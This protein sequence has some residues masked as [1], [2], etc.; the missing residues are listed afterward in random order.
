MNTYTVSKRSGLFVTVI[1]F[2]TILTGCSGIQPVR[3]YTPF[4]TTGLNTRLNIDKARYPLF[5][6]LIHGK[7]NVVE[8]NNEKVSI[9]IF[10]RYNEGLYYFVG[11]LFFPVIPFYPFTY[12]IDQVKRLGS[13]KNQNN[14]ITFLVQVYSADSCYWD[15]K[16]VLIRLP[17]GTE[18]IPSDTEIEQNP[19][20]GKD[21]ILKFELSKDD[22]DS[23]TLLFGGLT[24][25]GVPITIPEIRFNQIIGWYY[26]PPI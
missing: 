21:G 17:D 15:K 2:L 5:S 23:F 20:I 1:L 19:V 14:K 26:T 4:Q 8:F 9:I 25:E 6:G 22:V 18:I 7:D 24:I 11:P 16:D 10:S 3:Y 12:I 13:K